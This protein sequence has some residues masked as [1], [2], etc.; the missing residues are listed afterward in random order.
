MCLYYTW[1]VLLKMDKLSGVDW[2]N[3]YSH[4]EY[5]VQQEV[6]L[7]LER[8]NYDIVA[9][10]KKYYDFIKT[11]IEWELNNIGKPFS[12]LEDK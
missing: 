10:E 4:I 9:L 6:K 7:G 5:I 2:R 1:G 12:D 8:I 3:I 11:A